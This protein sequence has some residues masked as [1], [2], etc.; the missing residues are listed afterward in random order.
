MSPRTASSLK[1]DS[2]GELIPPFALPRFCCRPK[3]MRTAVSN[4]MAIWQK[5]EVGRCVLSIVQS[6][7]QYRFVIEATVVQPAENGLEA[8]DYP[9]ELYRSGL[10]DS[11]Q[12]AQKAALSFTV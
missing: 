12:A 3:R 9:E 6:R 5:A 8:Y 7:S 11:Q 2:V 10:Y 1:A 4:E